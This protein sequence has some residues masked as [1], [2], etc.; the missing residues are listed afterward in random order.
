[1]FYQH[2]SEVWFFDIY[3]FLFQLFPFLYHWQKF[4]PDLTMS[5]NT[6]GVFKKQELLTL[7]YY[8][9]SC[10]ITMDP[11]LDLKTRMF[12]Y[13]EPNSDSRNPETCSEEGFPGFKM[14]EKE[15]VT[16]V[17]GMESQSYVQSDFIFWEN[18]FLLNFFII[19]I[20]FP[21][22]I[23][24]LVIVWTKKQ[25]YE[26]FHGNQIWFHCL[27]SNDG[28]WKPDY[29]TESGFVAIKHDLN[30]PSVCLVGS[31][32]LLDHFNFLYC[33]FPPLLLFVLCP[34]LPV[35]LDCPFLIASS[36][37]F[38]KN[39]VIKFRADHAFQE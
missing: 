20:Y 32:L 6:T 11:K 3:F 21:Q 2:I 13:T 25:T 1:M 26:Q 22:H 38:T 10:L 35:S 7:R 30:T 27:I 14:T 23:D 16:N 34:M 24:L 9:R 37:F 36:I 33:V 12:L 28:F 18:N 8:L 39:V 31:V 17:T 19:E 29:E 4:S 5:S 15:H